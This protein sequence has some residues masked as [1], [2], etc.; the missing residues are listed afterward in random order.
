[1]LIKCLPSLMD[2]VRFLGVVLWLIASNSRA[3]VRV[4]VNMG[5]ATETKEHK[6]AHREGKHG[7]HRGESKVTHAHTHSQTHTRAA[8]NDDQSRQNRLS[9]KTRIRTSK[10]VVI[11]R[12]NKGGRVYKASI[13]ANADMAP[14]LGRILTPPMVQGQRLVEKTRCVY[15]FFVHC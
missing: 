10:S 1:M 12:R 2:F 11:G 9:I 15:L 6:K 7:G 14:S 13:S 4:T 3:L 5:V 8:T